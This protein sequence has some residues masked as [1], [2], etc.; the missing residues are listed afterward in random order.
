MNTVYMS[1]M[2]IYGGILSE[3]K[4]LTSLKLSGTCRHRTG[5]RPPSC[6]APREPTINVDLLDSVTD[7]HVTICMHS[8]FSIPLFVIIL[9]LR[10]S[11]YW[12]K[13]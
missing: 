11:C 3:Q 8:H 10:L 5:T 2:D 7:L 12:Q 6:V 1:Q 13:L 9:H 4:R